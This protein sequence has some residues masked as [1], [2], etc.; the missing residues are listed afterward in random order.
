MKFLDLNTWNRK[1]HF[2]FF[3]Q[4]DEPF[5]GITSEVDCTNALKYCK[6]NHISFF[7][8]YLHKSLTA[9]NAIEE[10]RYRIENK[11]VVIYDNIH[12]SATIARDDGTFA[13][14]FVPSDPDFLTFDSALKKE[15]ERIRNSTGL[16]LNN[17]TIRNDVI[18]YSSI[19]WFKFTGLT[20]ARN[21]KISDS[22]PKITFSKT[23]HKEDRMYLPVSVYVHHAL[24]DG[25]HVGK[26][27]ALFQKLLNEM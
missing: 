23:Y 5:F 3:S 27:L 6:D 8:F 2:E 1:E 21:L 9:A 25:L 14:S 20:H 15:T 4:F 7:S 17:K 10:F 26:Y 22:C 18:H 13:F 16:G 19:P 12:S 11:R 24:M